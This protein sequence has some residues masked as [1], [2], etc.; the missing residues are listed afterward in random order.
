[1]MATGKIARIHKKTGGRPGMMIAS[2][3]LPLD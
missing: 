2:K 1:M 3:G